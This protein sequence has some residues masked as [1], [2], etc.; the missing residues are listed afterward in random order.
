M[1]PIVSYVAQAF[2][3]RESKFEI[4]TEL[5]DLSKGP[6]WEAEEGS[7][8]TAGKKFDRIVALMKELEEVD[9]ADKVFHQENEKDMQLMSDYSDTFMVT[10]QQALNCYY[11]CSGAC[12]NVILSKDWIRRNKDMTQTEKQRWYCP[13]GRRYAT[14]YGVIVEMIIPRRIDDLCRDLVTTTGEA[15][16][17]DRFNTASHRAVYFQAELAPEEFWKVKGRY[18]RDYMCTKETLQNKDDQL[19]KI[20]ADIAGTVPLSENILK[21]VPG[22]QGAFNIRPEARDVIPK[23]DWDVFFEASGFEKTLKKTRSGNKRVVWVPPANVEDLKN[24][25]ERYDATK[26][27]MVDAE[28]SV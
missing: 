27:M 5:D 15:N 22:S 16:T 26:R 13:C 7:D 14:S 25:T 17:N 28:T 2:Q 10:N 6:Y 1:V 12:G 18:V 19:A 8:G 11:T 9:E 24:L 21:P 23:M 3:S 4:L 20:V